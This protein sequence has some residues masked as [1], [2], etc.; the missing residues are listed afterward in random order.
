[1]VRGIVAFMI[2]NA[3]F[4]IVAKVF[5]DPVPIAVGPFVWNRLA[6][7]AVLIALHGL[8]IAWIEYRRGAAAP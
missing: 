8:V 7:A 6:V 1:M 3:F 5:V 4:S 2:F